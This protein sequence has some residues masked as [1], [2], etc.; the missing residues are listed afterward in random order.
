MTAGIF[1]DCVEQYFGGTI[2]LIKIDLVLKKMV[3]Q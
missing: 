2:Y 3:D 1:I